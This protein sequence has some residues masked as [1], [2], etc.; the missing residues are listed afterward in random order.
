MQSEEMDEEVDRNSIE[1]LI[2]VLILIFFT[3]GE[4]FRTKMFFIVVVVLILLFFP[5]IVFGKYLGR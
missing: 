3:L 4:V 5:V 2:L 1:Y